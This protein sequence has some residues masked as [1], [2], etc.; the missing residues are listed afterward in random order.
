MA[1]N[2]SKRQQFLI[3]EA[4]ISSDRTTEVREVSQYIAEFVI[5]ED[6][7]KP[8]ITGKIAIMDDRGIFSNELGF[9]GSETL[10]IT[11]QG[12]DPDNPVEF[13]HSFL[14][15]GIDKMYKANEKTEIYL[16]NLVDKH[17]FY[18]ANI[19]LSKSYKGN[20]ENIVSAISI[21]ELGKSVDR[22]YALSP[23]LQE[24][25]KVIIPYLSPLKACSWLIN[26]ATTKNGSPFFFYASLYD[27]NLRIGDFDTQ[28]TRTPFNENLPL[29][30]TPAATNKAVEVNPVYE[31]TAIKDV[32]YGNLQDTLKMITSG[33]VGSRLSSI[34][35]FQN[36]ALSQHHTIRK[37]IRRL[38]QN[39]VIPSN[40][41]QNVFDETQ[42]I[43]ADD[44]NPIF[45]DDV[46]ARQFYKIN[47][48]GTYNSFNSYQDT[49]TLGDLGD[50]VRSISIRSMIE[51]NKLEIEVPG[52]LLLTRKVT[53]GDMI[54]VNF[55]NSNVTTEEVDAADKLD[56]ERS[57]NYLITSVRHTFSKTT[58]DVV[59]GISKLNT[60]T[61]S[62]PA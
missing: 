6:L 43:T 19:K 11:V 44:N 59:I 29:V 42:L 27:E 9:K 57:G 32:K 48:R 21:S 50:I 12:V 20:I 38:Q 24:N 28:Y 55:L 36:V 22:S 37:T 25:L 1:T 10:T 23:S 46:D 62:A 18:D 51:K 34:D 14:M 33:A 3:T 45:V 5:Y 52:A 56:R 35:V 40:S 53:V 26:R 60:K 4:V 8:Y 30:Y 7:Y 58:H 16:F 17:V 31:S 54:A 13:T 41:T 15:T 49:A 47:S 2:Q 61:G 39:N